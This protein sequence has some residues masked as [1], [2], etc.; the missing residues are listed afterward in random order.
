LTYRGEG[1]NLFTHMAAGRQLTVG[2]FLALHPVFSLEEFAL[3]HGKGEA[4]GAARNQLKYYLRRGRVK[5]VAR[6]IYAA[7][8]PGVDP[9]GHL[10]DRYLVGATARPGGLFC[11]HAALELLGA[12]HSLWNECTLHCTARRSPITIGLLRVLF[13]RTPT[14][15]RRAGVESLGVREIEHEGRRLRLTGP[16]RTLVEGF[17]RPHRVGGL[18]ELA[19][20][21]SGF[22]MLDFGIL[23][24]VLAAYDE[25]ATWAAVGWFVE[26][27]SDQWLPPR[28]F[29]ER[30]LAERP[31]RNQ[32]LLRDHRRGRLLSRWNLIVPEALL[33]GFEG[34]A[35]GASRRS[36][37]S[38]R[39]PGA[40]GR[41][42]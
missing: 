39:S 23:Q 26:T 21:A 27:W 8:P 6:G 42:P 37:A 1:G 2:E 33:L 29:I 16:E 30:C 13:L 20:A 9:E 40:T 22:A 17:R 14:A 35:P 4:L 32:F 11:Y 24:D 19:E 34:D 15:I 18:D 12:G 28:E 5:P 41:K 7:V 10:P 3:S 38:R 36:C 25:R 31:R